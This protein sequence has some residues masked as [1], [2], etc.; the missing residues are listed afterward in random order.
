MRAT[1]WQAE[2]NREEGAE[3]GKGIRHFGW[4]NFKTITG[5]YWSLGP[6]LAH[7]WPLLHPR[8]K[9]K[10][11]SFRNLLECFHTSRQTRRDAAL[12]RSQKVRHQLI[13]PC[14]ST[15]I[16]FLFSYLPP[17]PLPLAHL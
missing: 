6:E 12:L 10:K 1:S 7:T 4:D 13:V 8:M 11:E 2:K 17:L 16:F 14:A 9:R 5:Q 3:R 15:I